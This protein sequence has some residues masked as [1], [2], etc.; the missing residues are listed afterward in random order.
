MDPIRTHS[1]RRAKLSLLNEAKLPPQE[2]DLEEAVLGV[3]LIEKGA[4]EVIGDILTK[5][6]FYKDANGIIFKAITELY[7]E[8]SPIDLLT[9]TNRLR[10]S[11][12]LDVVGGA[13]YLTQLTNNVASGANIEYHARLIVEAFLAREVIR[14]GGEFTSRAFNGD[15]DVFELMEEYFKAVD[16]IKNYGVD[17]IQV[18]FQVEVDNRVAEKVQMVKDGVKFTGITTGNPKLDS[19]TGGWVKQNL[20]IIGAR[21]AM[22]KSVKGLNYAKHCALSGKPVAVFSLEMS[23]QELIDRYIVEEAEIPLHHYRSNDLSPYQ[24]DMIRNAAK[25]LKKLP[26]T[27]YDTPAINCQFVRRKAKAVIKKYGSIGLIVVDYLQLMTPDSKQG[28]REQEIGSISR[29]LKAIAKELGV[30]VIAL[31]QVGRGV[32]LTKDKRPDLSHL[33]ES[34]SIENDAD[35][36]MFIYRPS[37]YFEWGK[38]PDEEYSMES[39]GNSD[40][41]MAAELLIAKNRNG[42]PNA[43][44]K[45]RFIG[46]FSTFRTLEQTT[47]TFMDDSEPENNDINQFNDSPF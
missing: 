8:K 28:N 18:P 3:L 35:V 41:E 25:N 10:K 24:M 17:G 38:H 6:C 9:V 16:A 4:Y 37:Y 40:Y 36:V 12:E 14:I 30:P 2:I 46:A 33:R 34:G 23:T 29:G 47:T 22:G 44:I 19:I 15:E 45:E 31:A 5:E 1:S 39:I 43:K 13:F 26:I 32:E 20:I 21:P 42:V 7:N 11:N 27:I